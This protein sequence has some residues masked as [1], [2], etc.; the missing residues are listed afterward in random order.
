M[1]ST[2]HH[3]YFPNVLNVQVHYITFAIIVNPPNK[4]NN[5]LIWLL[6]I[7]NVGRCKVGFRSSRHCG[8]VYNWLSYGVVGNSVCRTWESCTL[9]FPCPVNRVIHNSIF[10]YTPVSYTHLEIL[11]C[12]WRWRRIFRFLA[13]DPRTE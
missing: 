9:A 13:L 4:N 5:N 3:L 8:N 2:I 12:C 6:C 7:K 10:C 1:I 11:F